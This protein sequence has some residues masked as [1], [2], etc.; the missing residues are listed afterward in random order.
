MAKAKKRATPK[1]PYA[2]ARKVM[3]SRDALLEACAG[4][5]DKA[6]KL[7]REK[8]K[9][10]RPAKAER[11]AKR[12]KKKGRNSASVIKERRA[13][14]RASHAAGH[15]ARAVLQ[16]VC[17]LRG[18]AAIMNLII[19]TEIEKEAVPLEEMQQTENDVQQLVMERAELQ[20]APGRTPHAVSLQ[21]VWMVGVETAKLIEGAGHNQHVTPASV[22]AVLNKLPA[23]GAL[24]LGCGTGEEVLTWLLQARAEAVQ[25]LHI[26]VVERHGLALDLLQRRAVHFGAVWD[27]DHYTFGD[28]ITLGVHEFEIGKETRGRLLQLAKKHTGVYAFTYVPEIQVEFEHVF[29]SMPAGAVAVTTTYNAASRR[30]RGSAHV[31]DV[32]KWLGNGK[33]H[34][35]SHA[36]AV[37]SGSNECHKLAVVTKA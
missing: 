1:V 27:E 18:Y 21:D 3:H 4:D 9:R 29:K 15:A 37:I 22:E 5:A 33:C 6:D 17:E 30:R 19:M 28:G 23:A 10:G 32:E 34:A 31:K 24:W 35:V 11:L 13:K 14:S 12:T 20:P 2:F 8:P 36:R 7:F 16:D 26:D 25:P